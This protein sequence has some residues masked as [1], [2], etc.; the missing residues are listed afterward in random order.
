M[1]K[2]FLMIGLP[3]SGKSFQAKMIAKKERAV[4]V[5]TDEIRRELFGDE[6]IQKNTNHV[7]F[8]VYS[9]MEKAFEEGK[10]VILDATNAER[11]KRIN[12]LKKFPDTKKIAVYIDTPFELCL[13]R[14]NERKRSLDHPVMEKIRKKLEIP[15]LSEGFHKVETIHEHV[16]YA[17]KKEKFNELL[18]KKP[19]YEELF[20]TLKNVSFFGE[21]INFDQE[22]PYH[23]LTLCYHTYHVL[24]YINE[25]C[26]GEDKL[27]LQ[28]AALFHDTGKIYTKKYKPLKGYC[29]Y[30]AHELVSSHIAHH[31]LYEL[32][33]EQ[34]FINDAVGIIEM[35]MKINREDGANEIYH[36]FGS[37][38]LTKLYQF[39]QADT[40]AK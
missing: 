37:D 3:G 38:M 22:N 39:N 13:E 33:F 24:E 14:N 17:I 36:L 2:L 35:H 25:F 32:G 26:E 1:N 15:F 19:S 23:S 18:E 6:T 21:M 11:E 31:F 20:G 30:W 16:D 5:S 10:N 9:R 34:K 29:S 12:V 27:L 28:I 4:I 8:E 40:F 7:F